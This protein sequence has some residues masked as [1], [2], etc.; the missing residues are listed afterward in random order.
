MRM[1]K[2]VLCVSMTQWVHLGR[3]KLSCT[4]W[5]RNDV[6]VTPRV[7]RFDTTAAL[8]IV[9]RRGLAVMKHFV[10]RALAIH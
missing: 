4:L 3:E 7:L 9:R 5:R 10:V 2:D 8:D 1:T 6:S